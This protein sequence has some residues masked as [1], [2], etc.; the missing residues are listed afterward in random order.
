M[1]N[2][3]HTWY[4]RGGDNEDAL[5]APQDD[6]EYEADR[7]RSNLV[8]KQMKAMTNTTMKQIWHVSQLMRTVEKVRTIIQND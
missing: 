4:N 8:K 1:T 6:Y 5:A 2:L 3:L 7:M